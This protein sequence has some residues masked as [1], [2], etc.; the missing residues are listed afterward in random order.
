MIES[1]SVTKSTNKAYRTDLV[2]IQGTGM[3][4]FLPKGKTKIVH[5]IL[6][7]K[8]A[9]DGKATVKGEVKGSELRTRGK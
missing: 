8:L 7:A 6:G 5:K 9:A 2:T 3:S 4:K 1:K